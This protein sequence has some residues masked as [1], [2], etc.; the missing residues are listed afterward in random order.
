MQIL[1]YLQFPI[2]S[3]NFEKEEQIPV[4]FLEI[5]RKMNAHIITSGVISTNKEILYVMTIRIVNHTGGGMQEL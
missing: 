3:P 2:L 1:P 5:L 4:L